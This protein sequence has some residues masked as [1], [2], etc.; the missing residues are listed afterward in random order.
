M[1]P[2]SLTF[3]VRKPTQGTVIIQVEEERLRQPN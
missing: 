3:V 1:S 2:P